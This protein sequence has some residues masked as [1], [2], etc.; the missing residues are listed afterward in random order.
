M[1][2]DD[3]NSVASNATTN[4]TTASE[5]KRSFNDK[6]NGSNGSNGS[7]MRKKSHNPLPRVAYLKGSGSNASNGISEGGNGS[8]VLPCGEKIHKNHKCLIACGSIE[9]TIGLIGRLKSY[10]F[11]LEETSAR[12]M[13][14]FARLTKIQEDL[15]SIIKS[16]TTTPVN[17]GKHT[18]SRFSPDKIKELE[19]ATLALNSRIYTGIPGANLLESDI[20]IIWSIVRRCERQVINARDPSLGVIV[21]DNVIMYM[22]KLSSYFSHLITHMVGKF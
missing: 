22:N 18:N 2:D 7:T 12:K 9:E 17:P 15:L 20:Y 11:N 13:F 19:D 16:I 3:N 1:S 10:H 4:A 5:T 8:T 14:I 6:S 21:E